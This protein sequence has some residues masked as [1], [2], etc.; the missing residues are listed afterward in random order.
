MFAVNRPVWEEHGTYDQTTCLRVSSEDQGQCFGSSLQ[1][2]YY[3][4]SYIV[5]DREC[6]GCNGTAILKPLL[7]TRT[8][9][10]DV[11]TVK[12]YYEMP[13]IE[14]GPTTCPIVTPFPSECGTHDP[15][16]DTYIAPRGCA[17]YYPANGD[18]ATFQIGGSDPEAPGEV[19]MFCYKYDGDYMVERLDYGNY[20][21]LVEGFF[22]TF[23]ALLFLSALLSVFVE[24]NP[25]NDAYCFKYK[26]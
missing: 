4:V 2:D 21:L 23:A 10:P 3:C 13:T 16:T 9:E 17:Y 15:E 11:D 1:K 6:G 7:R 25:Q 8:I 5:V 19:E 20:A 14:T 26:L 18:A 22:F 12:C 24:R